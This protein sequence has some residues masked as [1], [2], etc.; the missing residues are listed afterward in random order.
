MVDLSAI[1]RH[2]LRQRIPTQ[3]ELVAHVAA[4]VAAR[5]AARVTIHWQFTR[6][7]ARQK[8]L[9]HDQKIRSHNFPD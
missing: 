9:R 1:A 5:N 3:D 6:D 8:L 7:K 4:C 2:C